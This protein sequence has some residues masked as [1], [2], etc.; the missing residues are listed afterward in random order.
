MNP[1]VKPSEHAPLVA[2]LSPQ[3]A[4]TVQSTGY[5]DMGLFPGGILATVVVGA[6]GSGTTVDAKLQQATTSAGA[7]VKDVTGKG[8]TQLTQAGTDADKQVEINCRQDDLDIAGGFRWVR[9]TVTPATSTALIF[10]CIRGFGALYGPAA[11]LTT[12]DQVVG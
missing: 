6:L 1:N 4:T 11:D 2:V 8:I 10:A 9:L 12:V 5:V 7:G 3:S